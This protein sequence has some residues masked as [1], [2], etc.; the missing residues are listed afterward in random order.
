MSG[1]THTNHSAT[2]ANNNLPISQAGAQRAATGSLAAGNPSALKM[3]PPGVAVSMKSFSTSRCP[4]AAANHIS[5]GV[6]RL[7]APLPALRGGPRRTGTRR[8][9]LSRIQAVGPRSTH[10]ITE[11]DRW[12]AGACR[13]AKVFRGAAV[14]RPA[15]ALHSTETLR[16]SSGRADSP[17]PLPP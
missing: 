11:G 5:H 13:R 6:S 15:M 3:T 7:P 8:R 9:P 17:R 2:V 14:R 4:C 1:F 12:R 10:E 16:P